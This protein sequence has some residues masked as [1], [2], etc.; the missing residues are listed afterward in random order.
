MKE[1][2]CEQCLMWYCEQCLMW[3]LVREEIYITENVEQLRCVYW[4]YVCAFG[5]ICYRLR[6][7][8]PKKELGDFKCKRYRMYVIL[9]WGKRVYVKFTWLVEKTVS[10]VRNY[11]WTVEFSAGEILLWVTSS[12]THFTYLKL[13]QINWTKQ[14][15]CL[16]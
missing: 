13:P 9:M 12:A 6:S 15:D 14:M 4:G 1:F 8:E 3:W 5:F 16:Q 11:G 2:N 10:G 7:K